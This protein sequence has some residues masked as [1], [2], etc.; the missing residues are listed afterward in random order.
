VHFLNSD[1]ARSLFSIYLFLLGIILISQAIIECIIPEKMYS[2]QRK[3]IF[4]RWY[5]LHGLILSIGGLPLTFFRETF[6]GMIMMAAGIIVVLT[7]PFIFF[8]TAKVRSFFEESEK[9]MGDS[10]K[11]LMYL[12]SAVRLS[13]AVLI[14]FIMIRYEE[15]LK[16]LAG[17]F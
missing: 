5:P 14:L 7:G 6:A 12:D 10:R 1:F 15:V 3:W 11:K 16:T 17:F 9:E 8:Y 2:L 13:V 4:H